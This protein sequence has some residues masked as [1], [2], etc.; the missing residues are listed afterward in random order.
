LLPT[1]IEGYFYP[2]PLKPLKVWDAQ[3]PEYPIKVNTFAFALTGWPELSF[4]MPCAANL[5]LG[6]ST[7]NEQEFGLVYSSFLF[8]YLLI[9][10]QGTKKIRFIKHNELNRDKIAQAQGISAG[11]LLAKDGKFLRKHPAFLDTHDNKEFKD[12]YRCFAR[13]GRTFLYSDNEDVLHLGTV[14][15]NNKKENGASCEELVNYLLQ[16]KNAREIFF[17]DGGGSGQLFVRIG[18]EIL[19]TSD[20]VNADAR[21]LPS[22]LGIKNINGNK[23]ILSP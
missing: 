18:E 4:K 7:E 12:V 6:K 5:G 23:P 11:I 16:Y 20:D 10:N 14:A 3:Y 13:N 17:F 9:D 2:S 8:D 22:F 1:S 21:P 15:N 19:F